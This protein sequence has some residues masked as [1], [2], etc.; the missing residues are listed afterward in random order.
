MRGNSPEY[1]DYVHE[2]MIRGVNLGFDVASVDPDHILDWPTDYT[3]VEA[4]LPVE[5]EGLQRW[6]KV[7]EHGTEALEPGVWERIADYDDWA[8]EQ[9]VST[10]DEFMSEKL[11]SISNPDLRAAMK[12]LAPFFDDTRLFALDKEWQ[13]PEDISDL[14]ELTGL[15]PESV[16]MLGVEVWLTYYRNG[17][18]AL[19][20]KTPLPKQQV[21]HEQVRDTLDRI[22]N[23]SF[24]FPIREDEK[25]EFKL[26]FIEHMDKI[27][28]EDSYRLD[29]D[30]ILRDIVMYD[31]DT[32]ERVTG[33]I[34]DYMRL[35]SQGHEPVSPAKLRELIS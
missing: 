27:H 10:L 2:Q 6:F 32:L 13:L 1:Q 3:N 28:K 34:D 23:G 19:L 14:K 31:F 17:L 8:H 12:P 25:T 9:E 5:Q 26:H 21:D 16:Y 30:F 7:L 4:M 15:S 33:R 24:V 29:L 20:E 18:Q 11:D 22:D 35:R